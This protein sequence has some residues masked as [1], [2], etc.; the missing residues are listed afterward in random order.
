MNLVITLFFT[1]LFLASSNV[2]AEW[3]EYP[4]K[5]KFIQ[6][7]YDVL[8]GNKKGGYIKLKLLSNYAKPQDIEIKNQSISYLS[9]VD[10][11]TVNCTEK[12]K[13][14]QITAF[15]LYEDADGKG[16]NYKGTPKKFK[17]DKVQRKS[18][19]DSLLLDICSK[20]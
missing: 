12:T 14:I 17:W 5:G 9:R 15:E 19:L 20:A 6:Y 7:S 13:E 11:A 3:T 4:I 18:T 8:N 1:F 16:W 10:F 2:R